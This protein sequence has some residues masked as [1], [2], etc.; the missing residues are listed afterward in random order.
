ME[1]PALGGFVAL[2]LLRVGAYENVLND[3][4]KDAN[5]ASHALY[6]VLE[7]G[8]YNVFREAGVP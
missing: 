3:W 6:D 2:A 5:A 1:R 8:L 7:Q 4:N